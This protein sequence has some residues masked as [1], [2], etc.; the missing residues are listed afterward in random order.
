[1]IEANGSLRSTGATRRRWLG[2]KGKVYLKDTANRRRLSQVAG[3]AEA[4]SRRDRSAVARATGSLRSI[5]GDGSAS[6]VK[7]I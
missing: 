7:C 2:I 6:R 4:G 1:M 3:D 5:G